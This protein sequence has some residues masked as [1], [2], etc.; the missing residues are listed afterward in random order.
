MESYY[1]HKAKRLVSLRL[2]LNLGRSASN[3]VDANSQI[4]SPNSHS[5]A[6]GLDSTWWLGHRERGMRP[7]S[8]A[9]HVTAACMRRHR[10]CTPSNI[11]SGNSLGSS[12]R[13]SRGKGFGSRRQNPSRPRPLLSR[14][15]GTIR[16]F[17]THN[18]IIRNPLAR[19]RCDAVRRGR[20]AY[21]T[22]DGSDTAGFLSFG[23]GRDLL[24]V[25]V[26]SSS[27]DHRFA[28]RPSDVA[29]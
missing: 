6:Q 8:W 4:F 16:T 9:C 5:L 2:R 28:H 27:K 13:A 7:G 12:P 18:V 22:Q 10:G 29:E 26:P 15:R 20:H 1:P 24:I 11:V 14:L 23:L 17:R 21:S 25:P 19:R 3:L